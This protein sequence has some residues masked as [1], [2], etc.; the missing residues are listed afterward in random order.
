MSSHNFTHNLP[1]PIDPTVS[2]NPVDSRNVPDVHN[3]GGALGTFSGGNVDKH[4][5]FA[6]EQQSDFN[7]C[8]NQNTESSLGRKN[9]DHFSREGIVELQGGVDR[10]HIK[11]E[12]DDVRISTGPLGTISGGNI[13]KHGGF[14][15][16]N[17][18]DLEFDSSHHKQSFFKVIQ[19]KDQHILEQN[20]DHFSGNKDWVNKDEYVPQGALGTFSGGNVDKHG[21]FAEKDPNFD[22]S[23]HKQS[24]FEV[25]Q[26]K[27]QQILEQNEDHFSENKDWVNKDEYVPKGALG[28]FSGGNVDIHGGHAKEPFEEEIEA[29]KEKNFDF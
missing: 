7:S 11:P 1:N 25:K 8:A 23:H 27:D 15:G 6:G 18:G 10:P 24:F 21:G 9:E 5:G 14:A 19:N 22:P 2:R 12:P 20:E 17:P 4:G 28:T 16:T 13:D 29:S 3:V 26:N